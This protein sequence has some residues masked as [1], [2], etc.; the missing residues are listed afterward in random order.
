MENPWLMKS[1]EL[2]N[3]PSR[4]DGMSAEIEKQYREKTIFFIESLCKHSLFN[5]LAIH[6]Y[7]IN[8]SK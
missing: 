4:R 5:W 1:D 8:L 6:K 7:H 2:E 3:T